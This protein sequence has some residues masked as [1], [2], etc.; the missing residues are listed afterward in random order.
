MKQIYG[1]ISTDKLTNIVKSSEFTSIWTTT[2]DDIIICKDCEFRY[3]CLD[4]RAFLSDKNN[5]NSR[6]LKCKY[7]PYITKW[8]GEN[9][10]IPVE[11]YK[12]ESH[13]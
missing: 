4:C 6:P 13:V 8:E 12:K 9:G 3:I 1:Y 10:Y 2:K 7:N 11:N 5:P